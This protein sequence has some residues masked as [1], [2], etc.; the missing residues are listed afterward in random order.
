MQSMSLPRLALMGVA[1]EAS[2]SCDGDAVKGVGEKEG[3]GEKKAPCVEEGVGVKEGVGVMRGLHAL[4]RGN[5]DRDLRGERVKEA[6]QAPTHRQR[7]GAALRAQ[8]GSACEERKK[9]PTLE[10]FWRSPP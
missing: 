6:W 3:V 7:K 5:E 10:L 2:S 9:W 8:E 4:Y 1:P